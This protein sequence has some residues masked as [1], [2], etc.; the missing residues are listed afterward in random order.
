MQ[1]SVITESRSVTDLEQIYVGGGT[2]GRLQGNIGNVLKMTVCSLF[3][4]S[5]SFQS[6]QIVYFIYEK[7][8]A[9][10]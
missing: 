8:I 10:Q 7:F 1:T 2:R 4:S 5:D 9:C 6:S 3:S